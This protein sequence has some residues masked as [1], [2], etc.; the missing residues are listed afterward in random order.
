M[1]VFYNGSVKGFSG[2]MG[3]LIFR[4]LPNG[5]MVVSQAPRKKSRKEKEK[6]KLKRTERQKAHNH[7]FKRAVVYAKQAAKVEPVYTEI[8]AVT[9]MNNAYNIALSDWLNAPQIHRIERQGGCIRVEASDKVMVS[10]LLIT[11]LNG[12]GQ[13]LESGEALRTEGN[14]WEFASQVEGT[15][16]MAEARDLAGNV[17]KLVR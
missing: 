5:T 11:V 13:V 6:A 4:Q 1:K 14:W 15:T 17:T 3:N 12:E 8:A 16:V 2:R 9:P 7:R 10:R